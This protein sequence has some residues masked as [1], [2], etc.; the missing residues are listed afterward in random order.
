MCTTRLVYVRMGVEYG[1][2][3]AYTGRIHGDMV[4]DSIRMIRTHACIDVSIPSVEART[5]VYVNLFPSIDRS[6]ISSTH[7]SIDSVP[8][9]EARTR[10]RVYV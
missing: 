7:I 1:Y 2:Y 4:I 8:S 9:V 10:F 5:R 6:M 3:H